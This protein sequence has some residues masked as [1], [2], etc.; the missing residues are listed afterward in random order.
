M[1]F[2]EDKSVARYGKLAG[3]VFAYFFFTTVLFLVLTLLNKIPASWTYY[4]VMGVTFL[5]VLIG[6]G[7]KRFLI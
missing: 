3:Y 7:L 2:E 5:V 6:T 1:I 4:N